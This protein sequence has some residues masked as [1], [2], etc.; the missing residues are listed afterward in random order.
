MNERV[1]FILNK[2]FV[3]LKENLNF[4]SHWILLVLKLLLNIMNIIVK[5]IKPILKSHSLIQ[6]QKRLTYKF[7]DFSP[8]TFL[9]RNRELCR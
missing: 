5:L 1:L 4:N 8:K 9:K 3:N 6:P 2:R 7:A